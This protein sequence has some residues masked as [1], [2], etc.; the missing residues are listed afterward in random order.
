M[1]RYKAP[2]ESRIPPHCPPPTALGPPTQ[3]MGRFALTDWI[4]DVFC[5]RPVSFAYFS[6]FCLIVSNITNINQND[7][8]RL[9]TYKFIMKTSKNTNL[10]KYK[11]NVAPVSLRCPS[12]AAPGTRCRAMCRA[13]VAPCRARCRARCRAGVAPCRAAPLE[14][15]FVCILS[16][17]EQF[18][19]ICFC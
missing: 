17:C 12:G 14:A 8:E 15:R 9:E 16:F 18:P 4:L 3:D 10:C 7:A 11:L 6:T 2:P 19:K 13:G 5:T 1:H